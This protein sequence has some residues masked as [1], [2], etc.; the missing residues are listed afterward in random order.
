MDNIE[1][2]IKK[3][4]GHWTSQQFTVSSKADVDN[5]RSRFDK[6]DKKSKMKI[7]LSFIS[8]DPLLRES[9]A[10]P[11][12]RLLKLASSDKDEVQHTT[13][14]SSTTTLHCTGYFDLII[15]C[16]CV[17]SAL[18]NLVT[19]IIYAYYMN[20]FLHHANPLIGIRII[21][22]LFSLFLSFFLAVGTNSG[23]SRG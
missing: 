4:R 9:L 14:H 21:H 22:I 2:Q 20:V 23:R 11:L 15:C 7:M 13:Q 6:C 16:L 18:L 5:I 10:P 19:K 12:K 8:M 3:L 1:L 17:N